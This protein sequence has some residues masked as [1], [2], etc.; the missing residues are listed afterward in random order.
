MVA[1]NLTLHAR[2]VEDLVLG[3]EKEHEIEAQLSKIEKEWSHLELSFVQADNGHNVLQPPDDV[4]RVLHDSLVE[5]Q[6]LN[7]NPHVIR[8][9]TF[10][11][12]VRTLQFSL[13]ATET[14]LNTWLLAQHKHSTLL[15][16]FGTESVR[17]KC[18]DYMLQFDQIDESWK[19]M[20][21]QASLMPN[22]MET[23]SADDRDKQVRTL[24]QR[25]E[26]L[27]GKMLNFLE[28]HRVAFPRLYL[29]SNEGLF[30]L[31]SYEGYPKETI[32]YLRQCFPGLHQVGLEFRNGGENQVC[33]SVRDYSSERLNMQETIACDGPVQEW[34]SQ[35]ED[36]LH[37]SLHSEFFRISK[38]NQTS[39]LWISDIPLQLL[40]LSLNVDQCRGLESGLTEVQK[41]SQTAL[42]E[43]MDKQLADVEALAA[44]V[45]ATDVLSADCKK[46]SDM[47]L[48]LL[49][50]RDL[51]D[52]LEKGS[53]KT[54]AC[55]EW[56]SQLRYSLVDKKKKKEVHI[57]D[58]SLALIISLFCVVALNCLPSI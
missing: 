36:Q 9:S 20:M 31:L 17:A 23:C 57:Q 41:G 28:Q 3:A 16:L 18:G 50:W 22:V 54:V 39:E 29:L 33:T 8:N 37:L 34:I 4:L 30:M 45:R 21:L 56:Q 51:T 58:P 47:L 52:T 27:Q 32:P 19:A 26:E 53:E 6:I 1:L 42:Q 5:V 14:L 40:V 38:M 49:S 24:L 48:A 55:F 43:V 7:F 44:H 11:E 13:G 15:A 25:L 10:S 12:Q 2:E 35:L 46:A